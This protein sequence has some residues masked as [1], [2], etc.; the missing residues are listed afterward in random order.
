MSGEGQ[1][2]R[3]KEIVRFLITGA[4]CFAVE[5]AILVLLKELLRMDTLLATPIAF[6]GSV[7][8][9][10]LLCV[11]WVFEGTKEAGNATRL[12]FLITS[13]IGLALNEVLMLLFR[14][15]LGEEAVLLVLFGFTVNMYMLNKAL[16]TLLV[17]VWNYF[18]KR[19]ILRSAFVAELAQRFQKK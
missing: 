11:A 14:F 1:S 13:V 4:V 12:G 2:A 7:I 9:N 15:A 3:L 8:V 5:F 18:T 16:A 6:L 19:A 10:Y 17:M